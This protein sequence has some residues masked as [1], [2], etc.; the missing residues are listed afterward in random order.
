MEL[1]IF[2][3]IIL[4]LGILDIL[5]TPLIIGKERKPFTYWSFILAILSFI[6]WLA[7]FE[8]I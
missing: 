3:K 7:A 4:I 5:L 2:A 6:L 1:N 8:I